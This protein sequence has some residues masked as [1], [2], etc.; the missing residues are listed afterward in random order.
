MTNKGKLPATKKKGFAVS[1][2]RSGGVF[3]E[4]PRKRPQ[5]FLPPR[6][7]RGGATTKKLKI[8]D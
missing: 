7:E 8:N 6:R 5:V 3:R 1:I 4:E 2:S